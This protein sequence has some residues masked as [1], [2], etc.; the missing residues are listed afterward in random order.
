M[1][2]LGTN[3]SLI[4]KGRKNKQKIIVGKR[5][6]QIHDIIVVKMKTEIEHNSRKFKKERVE[7]K[8]GWEGMR[9]E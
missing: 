3:T 7:Q 1:R 8:Q 5:A 4:S 9:K 6:Y 2:Q